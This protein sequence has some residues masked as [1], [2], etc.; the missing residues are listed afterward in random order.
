MKTMIISL[1]CLGLTF[2]LN[3]QKKEKIKK[4]KTP[5][6]TL[7]NI[8]ITPLNISYLKNV[9]DKNTPPLAKELENKA[10]RY[11]VTEDPLFDGRFEAYEVIFHNESTENAKGKII[12]TYDGNGKII[13]SIEDH[14]LI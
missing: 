7:E 11:N 4:E 5:E 2:T 3:A 6:I 14:L 1:L 8:T 9:Q 13:K 10:A 12:A